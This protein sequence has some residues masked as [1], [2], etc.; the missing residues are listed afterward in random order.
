MGI[1]LVSKVSATNLAID[2][3]LR[4]LLRD[5]RR[6]RIDYVN[7]GLW[8]APLDPCALLAA[9]RYAVF[10]GHLALGVEGPDG[11][12]T[13]YAVDGNDREAACA[14]TDAPADV[15]MTLSTLGALLLG[16]NRFTE[17]AQAGL[18][19]E[20]AAGKLTYADAMFAT[21]PPPALMSGF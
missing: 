5:G 6:V 9:R 19:R 4:H 8:I 17:Y 20:H 3:P 2:D 21:S 7:D 18:V 1:D 10:D 16:G 14:I 15:S 11:R 13:T 12:T